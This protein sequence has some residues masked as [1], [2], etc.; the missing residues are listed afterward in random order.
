MLHPYLTRTQPFW[1]MPSV[2]QVLNQVNDVW[3]A[4]L[5]DLGSFS[6]RELA[7]APWEPRAAFQVGPSA[8]RGR[9]SKI[10]DRVG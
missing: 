4:D 3:Y 5:S 2:S 10:E 6:F 9:N 1:G 7:L 8:L